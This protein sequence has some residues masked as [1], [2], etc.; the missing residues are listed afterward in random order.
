MWRQFES[1]V[2]QQKNTVEGLMYMLSGLNNR[3]N[4][5]YTTNARQSYQQPPREFDDM[6][7]RT[8]NN[9]RTSNRGFS[10][11]KSSSKPFKDPDV[12]EPPPPM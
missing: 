1:N 3:S 5:S 4:L 8:N 6:P 2:I 7:R 11:Q 9:F 12:W 10:I